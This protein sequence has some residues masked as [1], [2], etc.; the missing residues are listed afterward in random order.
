MRQRHS[1]ARRGR[2][3][4]QELRNQEGNNFGGPVSAVAK[5]VITIFDK[6]SPLEKA[7]VIATA[8]TLN[9]SEQLETSEREEMAIGR[10][11]KQTPM[12]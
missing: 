4:R 8:T 1:R 6:P 9:D 11:I 3:W 10:G 5:E 2:S 12:P 7:S